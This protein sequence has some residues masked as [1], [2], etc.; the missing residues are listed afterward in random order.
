MNLYIKIKKTFLR[1][2]KMASCV[3]LLI[4]DEE[5]KNFAFSFFNACIIFFIIRFIKKKNNKNIIYLKL[6]SK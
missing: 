3:S 4:N 2:T 6:K 5:K 1:F